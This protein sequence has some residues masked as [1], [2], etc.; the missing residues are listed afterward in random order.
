MPRSRPR[1]RG[2]ETCVATFAA[3]AAC[4]GV[5][6]FDHGLDVQAP[7]RPTAEAG[8][9]HDAA[10]ADGGT[11]TGEKPAPGRRAPSADP[12]PDP[13]QA[14]Q[15]GRPAEQR[16]SD[17]LRVR[18]PSI[19]VAAPLTRLGLTADGTLEAPPPQDE[20]LAGWY[21]DGTPPGAVGTA[22]VAGHVDNADGPS[23]FYRLGAVAK[24]AAVEVER[25]DGFTAVFTVDAVEVYEGPDF[26]DEKVYGPSPRPELRLITCGGTFDEEADEYTGNVVVFAHLT[27]V[28][29]KGE[30]PA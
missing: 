25:R 27:D 26:P 19:D 29:R 14:E 7:P 22:V 30:G 5:W 23:V 12:G 10:P 16:A 11:N 17:P 1:S 9:T 21:A 4:V 3:T 6:L 13:D 28:L 24:G 20:D 2:V 18:I 8:F 15:T